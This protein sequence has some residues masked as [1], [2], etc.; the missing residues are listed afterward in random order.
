MTLPDLSLPSLGAPFHA[1]ASHA[2]PCRA[3]PRPG[4]PRPTPKSHDAALAFSAAT[5]RPATVREG[6]SRLPSATHR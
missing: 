5:M 1:D 2:H 4:L 3:L 6:R